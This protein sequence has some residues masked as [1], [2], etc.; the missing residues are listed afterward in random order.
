MPESERLGRREVHGRVAEG[1]PSETRP[2][3]HHLLSLQ[4]SVGNAAV[5]ELIQRASSNRLIVE[6]SDD[7]A[8]RHADARAHAVVGR[9]SHAD[10]AGAGSRATRD[11]V[12]VGPEGG[13]VPAEVD[14]RIRQARG[15]GAPLP[16][17][18][19][20]RMEAGFGQDLGDVN[21]HTDRRSSALNDQLS[22]QAF[23]VGRDVF[24]RPGDAPGPVGNDALLAHELAHVAQQ[25]ASTARRTIR[26]RYLAGLGVDADRGF[27]DSGSRRSKE[28]KAIDGAVAAYNNGFLGGAPMANVAKLAQIKA[29]ISAWKT[30]KGKKVTSAKRYP[31]VQAL[32]HEVDQ[33]TVSETAREQDRVAEDQRAGDRQARFGEIHPDL[34]G[35]AKR[36]GKGKDSFKDTAVANGG[37]IAAM[38]APR[39]QQG[40]LSATSIADMD[41]ADQAETDEIERGSARAAT[42]TRGKD[43][44]DDDIQK[45]MDANVNPVTKST[46]Y[47][48]LATMLGP[49]GADLSPTG[50]ITRSETVAGVQ[51]TFHSNPHGARSDDRE[52]QVRAAVQKVAAAGVTL[53]AFQAYLPALARSMTVSKTATGC[54]VEVSGKQG[55][56]AV[57]KAP[58]EMHIS[59]GNIDN[60]IAE[61]QDSGE[62]AFSST[63]LDPTGIGTMIHEFGHMLHHD[64]EPAKFWD[65]WNTGWAP[66]DI[67]GV[68]VGSFVATSVSQYAAGNPRE[69]VA[70]VFLNLVYGKSTFPQEIIDLYVIF[71]GPPVNTDDRTSST[72]GEAR[73]RMGLT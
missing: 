16:P 28:L 1:P 51:I 73:S 68:P 59:A 8:E 70:E 31:V 24:L 27:S 19:R 33:L 30:S 57:Y 35:A 56:R 6:A 39:D 45:V 2:A 13:A 22:A 46:I 54:E 44:S 5:G 18:V 9:S 3:E 69:M 50:E 42:L 15:G 47:P 23:T 48:E 49:G 14:R 60:P 25:T 40:A 63:R 10:G 52:A 43:V 37:R 11:G 38:I 41:A 4:R 65:L 26:R 58:D 7:A 36:A 71:G 53:P 67:G 32:E 62:Y 20:E 34:Q 64:R 66:M 12:A 55:S 61:E 29:A 21:V 17:E 72:V